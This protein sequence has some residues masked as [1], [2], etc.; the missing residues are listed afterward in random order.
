M[1]NIIN[2]IKDAGQNILTDIKGL[3]IQGIEQKISD[4]REEKKAQE[5]ATNGNVA[6]FVL[7]LIISIVILYYGYQYFKMDVQRYPAFANVAALLLVLSAL[8]NLFY[9]IVMIFNGGNTKAV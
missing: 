8:F 2:E 7:T 6:I 9:A 5:T 3:D 4:Y 1:E